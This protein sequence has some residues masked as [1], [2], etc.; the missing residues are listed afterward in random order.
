M[1][2]TFKAKAAYDQY[3]NRIKKKLDES[4]YLMRDAINVLTPEDTGEL[5]RNNQVEESKLV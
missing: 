3:A 5:E 1:K 2:F 4:L